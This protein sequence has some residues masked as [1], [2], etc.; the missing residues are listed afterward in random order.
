MHPDRRRAGRA[1]RKQRRLEREQENVDLWAAVATIFADLPKIVGA[2][3][4]SLGEAALSVGRS[5]QGIPEQNRL[6]LPPAPGAV[7]RSEGGSLSPTH[8]EVKA[9]RSPRSVSGSE[10]HS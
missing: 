2:A 10:D 9:L 6:A 7:R 8:S 1:I 5:M 4:V 3:F